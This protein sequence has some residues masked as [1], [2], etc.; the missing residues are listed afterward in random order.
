MIPQVPQQLRIL[1]AVSAAGLGLALALFYDVL[2]F[3]V[4]RGKIRLFLC[5]FITFGLA[6]V[7]LISFAVSQS[8][9]GVFRWYMAV[10]AGA[11]YAAYLWGIAPFT[12]RVFACV[13][14]ALGLPFRMAFRFVLKPF[15]AL[16]CKGLAKIK[17]SFVLK[18]KSK[19]KHLRKEQ[20]V[21]YNSN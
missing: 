7:L 12:A 5:D 21:L 14:F 11:G 1:D 19:R 15:G 13:R 16:V 6:G 10:G 3:F 17:K 4:R 20:K 8:Y 9:T 18:H 2:R